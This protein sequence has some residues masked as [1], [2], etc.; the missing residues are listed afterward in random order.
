MLKT[1][2]E[3]QVRNLAGKVP[4][5]M[6]HAKKKEDS[7]D[8]DYLMNSV[9]KQDRSADIVDEQAKIERM[10]AMHEGDDKAHE[11]VILK[12][13]PLSVSEKLAF[14]KDA[15]YCMVTTKEML[16]ILKLELDSL[17]RE[18]GVFYSVFD[19]LDDPDV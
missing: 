7:D 17:I 2:A 14:Y 19:K 4:K 1:G 3:F 15:D 6:R 11:E 13:S 12:T 8:D 5:E 16:P 9:T 18:G 10:K